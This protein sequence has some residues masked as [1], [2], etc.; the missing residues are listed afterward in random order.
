MTKFSCSREYERLKAEN[1]TSMD[2]IPDCL[3]ALSEKG[4]Y[5]FCVNYRSKPTEKLANLFKKLKG[6]NKNKKIKNSS[7]ISEA[8]CSQCVYLIF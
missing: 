2:D 1:D 6:Y 8:H 3:F 7:S 5:M 4:K